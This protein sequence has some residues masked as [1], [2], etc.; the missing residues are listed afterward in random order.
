M[1]CHPP[2][3]SRKLLV[4]PLGLSSG[5]RAA[6]LPV[7]PLPAAPLLLRPCCGMA[8]C[9]AAACAAAVVVCWAAEPAEPAASKWL[10][11]GEEERKHCRLERRSSF[12]GPAGRGQGKEAL[13][14]SQYVISNRGGQMQQAWGQPFKPQVGSKFSCC[15]CCCCCCTGTCLHQRGTC[16]GRRRLHCPLRSAA[17]PPGAHCCRLGS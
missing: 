11:F 1:F 8:P 15:C 10:G 6:P 14:C 2:E 3:A 13:N 7:L 9:C 5:R 17:T 4:A 16:L 12:G